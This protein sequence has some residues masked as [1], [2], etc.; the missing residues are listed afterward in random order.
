MTYAD[1]PE[2]PESRYGVAEWKARCDLA[3]LYRIAA[4]HGMSDLIYNHISLRLPDAPEHL[5]INPFGLLFSKV[6]ASSLIKIDHAGEI[7]DPHAPANAR[8]N[9]AGVV[10]HSAV[11]RAR[12]EMACVIHSHTTAGMAV[13]AQRDGLLPLTQHAMMFHGRIGYHDYESFATQDDERERIARDFGD[14]EVMILRNHGVLVGGRSV[15]EAFHSAYHLERACQAQVMAQAS[16]S[17]NFPAEEIALKTAA[18][19]ASIPLDHYDFFWTQCHGL[20][21]DDGEDCRR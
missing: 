10:I 6:T 9:R 18:R 13:S 12:P 15:G 21:P 5:L 3:I 17:L 7:V 4:L 2:P 19:M 14:N 20:L 16:A 8:I 1:T 11:H